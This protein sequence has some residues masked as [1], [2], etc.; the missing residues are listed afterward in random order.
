M[1]IDD[2]FLFQDFV[3]CGQMLRHGRQGRVDSFA[4][5]VKQRS[6]D[7]TVDHARTIRRDGHHA[8]GQEQELEEIIHGKPDKEY[9]QQ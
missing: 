1:C 2:D 7:V 4:V 5:L 3:L 6:Y 9:F 8:P